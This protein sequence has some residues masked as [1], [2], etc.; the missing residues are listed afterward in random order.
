M[1][2]NGIEKIISGG[3]IVPMRPQIS[4]ELTSHGDIVIHTATI[5]DDFE[6]VELK[7]IRFPVECAREIAEELIRL[8]DMTSS[9]I[10]GDLP[11]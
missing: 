1:S 10:E 6:N 4:V 8:A 11:A 3:L 5:A 7:D 9:G 2:E